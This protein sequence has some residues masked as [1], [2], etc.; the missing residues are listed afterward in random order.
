MYLLDRLFGQGA[1]AA[2]PVVREYT[3]GER[4]RLKLAAMLRDQSRWPEGFRWDFRQFSTCAMGLWDGT[5]GFEFNGHT[6]IRC[7]G[8]IAVPFGFT[9]EGAQRIFAG[10]KACRAIFY[11]ANITPEMVA[12]ELE[13]TVR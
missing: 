3:E 8:D 13:A 5:V 4:N 11:G 7:W 10:E 6:S 9:E 2:T 12:D 1:R